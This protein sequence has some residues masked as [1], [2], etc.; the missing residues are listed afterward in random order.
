MAQHD[1]IIANDTAANV[2]SDINSALAA[3]V[4]QNSGAS[5]P[6]A[7][8]ANMLWYDS[9]NNLLKMRDEADAA[10]ITLG[11]LDQ[12]NGIFKPAVNVGS[13]ATGDIYYRNASG[14][15]TRLPIGSTDQVLKVASGLPSWGDAGG[16]GG[17]QSVQ[18]FTSSG[19]WTRPAGIT[20]VK[21]Y[22]TGGGGGGGNSTSE[23][24]SGGATAIKLLDVSSISS[25]TITVGAGGS[26]GSSRGSG[27]TSSWSDGTNTISAGGG[28]NN[29]SP[30]A[31]GGDINLNGDQS[32]FSAVAG[33]YWANG[34]Y[35]YIANS[36]DYG[37]AG[38][39]QD[40]SSGE[41]GIQGIVI[42]EEYA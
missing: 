24:N 4:S 25:A 22:A 9:T 28:V 33:S 40:G 21:I 10:W 2:R 20:K 30:S 17:L 18:V 36:T 27:G 8:Y 32:T 7:T 26:G 13:D 31:S 35:Q 6:S 37:A 11:E 41:D 38:R 39:A 3:I 16:G 5:A 1:Y 12:S 29:N 34:G 23:I 42:V 15:F 19:T 14:V